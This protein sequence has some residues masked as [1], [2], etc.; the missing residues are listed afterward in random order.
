MIK[1]K[2]ISPGIKGRKEAIPY[3]TRDILI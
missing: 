1:A 2:G 3:A